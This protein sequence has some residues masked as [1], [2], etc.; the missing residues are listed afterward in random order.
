MCDQKL[1]GPVSNGAAIR[2]HAP[3]HMQNSHNRLLCEKRF[4]AFVFVVL[5]ELR[6]F[7]V[8][9]SVLCCVLL[10]LPVCFYFSFPM[11]C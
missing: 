9:T 2:I 8:F 10:Y 7:S 3:R 4:A 1:A 11:V 6:V 5:A